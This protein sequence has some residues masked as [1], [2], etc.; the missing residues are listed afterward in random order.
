MN[1]VEHICSAGV[2]GCGGAGFPSHRK[3]AS[4]VEMVVA[5]G[6]EC[7]PLLHKDLELMMREPEAVVSGMNLLMSAT[8]AQRGIIGVKKKYEDKLE[9]ITGALRGTNMK[10][11][12][13][14]G[15]VEQG[16]KKKGGNLTDLKL[17]EMDALW[18]EAKSQEI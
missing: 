12:K 15:F 8:G 13:R 3:A 6:A 18:N 11:K 10:F 1:L 14:F 7:E 5:N 2:V 9:G 4:K 17:E 16:A